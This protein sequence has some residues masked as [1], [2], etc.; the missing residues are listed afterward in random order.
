MTAGTRTTFR[1]ESGVKRTSE[2]QQDDRSNVDAVVRSARQ[3]KLSFR[4]G[5]PTGEAVFRIGG[6]SFKTSAPAGQA[7]RGR[8]DRLRS[9]PR[10]A[11]RPMSACPT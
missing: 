8:I 6:T 9:S 10:V 3:T 5:K 2:A 4:L 1:F 11:R 7:S